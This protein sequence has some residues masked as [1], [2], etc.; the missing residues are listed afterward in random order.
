MRL[1]WLGSALSFILLGIITC[2][3]QEWSGGGWFAL[4]VLGFIVLVMI[5]VEVAWK[6]THDG[7]SQKMVLPFV[8]LSFQ[9]I[10]YGYC[11]SFGFMDMGRADARAHGRFPG[12]M[13]CG[14]HGWWVHCLA[15]GLPEGDDFVESVWVMLF[16][17]V[18]LR[19]LKVAFTYPPL[20]ET[21]RQLLRTLRC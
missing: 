10:A 16:I 4:V 3:D 11:L 2:T 15:A 17:S 1:K 19:E 9:V 21:L 12:G 8:Y 13:N 14:A 5:P 18:L 6:T 20:G 7:M